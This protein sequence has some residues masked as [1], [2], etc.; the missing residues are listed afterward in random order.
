LR[1]LPPLYADAID[2]LEFVL[3]RAPSR[4][5][6][7]RRKL[8]NA[9]LYGLYEGIPLTER[10]TQYDFAV[11]D[12]ITIYWGA[13]LRD[14]PGEDELRQ[15]VRNTVYHELAHYFGLDEDDLEETRVR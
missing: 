3:E 12:R 13:L 2:N 10:T 8:G 5:D 14:F 6:R 4:R 1:D 7:Q 9:T 11:P 15:E